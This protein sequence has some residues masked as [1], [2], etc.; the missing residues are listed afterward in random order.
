M[1]IALKSP[2][3]PLARPTPR[4]GPVPWP[5]KQ[6]QRVELTL[7]APLDPPGRLLGTVLLVTA[8]SVLILPDWQTPGNPYGRECLP[9]HLK[10]VPDQTAPG[11]VPVSF[12]KEYL[13][14]DRAPVELDLKLRTGRW[15]FETFGH[16]K[17]PQFFY[18]T[19]REK[20]YHQYS[21]HEIAGVRP[22]DQ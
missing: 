17:P 11:W 6:W 2:F 16:K 4:T 18:F 20:P 12:W 21:E 13:Y 7:R 22:S 14:N 19:S 3:L 15:V 5:P 10:P 8:F 1:E 9:I